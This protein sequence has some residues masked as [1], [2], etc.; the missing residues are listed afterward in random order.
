MYSTV[1][2]RDES[3]GGKLLSS[4][5]FFPQFL[6]AACFIPLSGGFGVVL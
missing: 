3:L 2:I 4:G 1:F 5:I 6:S